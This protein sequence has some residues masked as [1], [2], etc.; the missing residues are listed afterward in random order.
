MNDHEMRSILKN[1]SVGGDFDGI[2]CTITSAIRA[3]RIVACKARAEDMKPRPESEWS[4]SDG[5]VLWWKFP[6]T[7]A[8]WVGTPLDLGRPIEITIRD[9]VRDY[10]YTQSFGGWPG[11]HTH[12]TPLPEIPEQ[13]DE[14]RLCRTR[15]IG[16]T[17]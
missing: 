1:E 17:P 14:G 13:P 12:W 16:L 8:P 3:M 7:E 4:E 5:D 6:V 9:S 10:T 2:W 15:L 11:Y